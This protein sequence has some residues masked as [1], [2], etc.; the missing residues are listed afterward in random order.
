MPR[1]IFDGMTKVTW[2]V[3]ADPDFP[4]LSELAAGVDLEC[5]LTGDGLNINFSE[6][7]VDDAALCEPFDAELP[8][9]YK[10]SPELTLKRLNTA[11]AA[12]DTAWYTFRTRGEAGAL[13]VRVGVDSDTAWTAGQRAEVYPGTV[14]VRRRRPSARNTQDAFML[15]IFGSEEP[16]LD[17]IVVAS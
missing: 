6:N 14:G 3:P 4:A 15:T 9:S 16:S 7:A 5:L 1:Y 12:D 10:V 11:A 13:A 8:G 17:A 2:F